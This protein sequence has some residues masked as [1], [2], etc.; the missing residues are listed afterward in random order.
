[1][2]IGGVIVGGLLVALLA[3]APWRTESVPA[4]SPGTSAPERREPVAEAPKPDEP[5]PTTPS[6]A[7]AAPPV[8]TPAPAVPPPTPKAQP[9]RTAPSKPPEV[10]AAQLCEKLSTSGG[11]QCVA[12]TLPVNP[13]PVYFYSRVKSTTDT[14]VQHRWYRG[15]RL[16]QEVSLRIS[17]NPSAGYRTYSRQTVDSEGSAD[18]RVELRTSD[19]VLLHEERFVVR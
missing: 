7:A 19:G 15:D 12:P 3:T 14:T 11:W 16:R 13:G 5:A 10:A 9:A 17:A 8:I 2:I 1:M 4:D 18:W 6:A